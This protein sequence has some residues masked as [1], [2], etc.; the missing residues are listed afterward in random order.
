MKNPFA[1]AIICALFI[2]AAHAADEPKPSPKGTSCYGKTLR[3]ESDPNSIFCRGLGYFPN[4]SSIYERGYRVVSTMS[5]VESA[6]STFYIFIE[7]DK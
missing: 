4:V 2:T 1:L 3:G 6:G 5:H 7:K